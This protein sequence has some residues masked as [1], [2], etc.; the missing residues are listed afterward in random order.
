M[1]NSGT[2]DD[3][4]IT[5]L[6]DQIADV[7]ELKPSRSFW[8]LARQLYCTEFHWM[9]PNDD[10]RE[11]DGKCLRNEFI[12]DCDI[13]DTEVNWLILPCSMLEMMIALARRASFESQGTPGDWFWKFIENLEIVYADDNYSEIVQDEIAAA[14]ER[15]NNRTYDRNGDGGMFPLKHAEYDQRRVELWYQLSAF[16]LEGDYVD[17]GP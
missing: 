12:R 4:Y 13:Q 16:I 2:L 10:N 8:N 5:W 15:I 14:L 7:K 11:E 6:Y 17:H 9:I 1:R 3:L